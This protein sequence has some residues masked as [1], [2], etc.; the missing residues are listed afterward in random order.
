MSPEELS[1]KLRTVELFKEFPDSELRQLASG[2]RERSIEKGEVVVR[3]GEQ[4]EE[5][6]LVLE[7][8]FEVFLRQESLGFEKE[9]N[10]LGPGS[11][12]GEVS[13]L[14][15]GPRLASVRALSDARALVLSRQQLMSMLEHSPSLGLGLC[16]GMAG[17]L[18]RA[19]TG[20]ASFAHV[21]LDDYPQLR[22][23]HELIPPRISNFCQAL[24]LARGGDRVTVAMVNPRDERARGFLRDVLRRYRVEF[25][26]MSER[27]FDRHRELLLGPSL[28]PLSSADGDQLFYVNAEGGDE[29]LGEHETATVLQDV[30]GQAIRV[31]ASDI[32]FEPTI[33]A[34]RV[35]LRIDGN[36]LPHSTQMP[37]RLFEQ[38]ISRL[39]VMSGMDI[40][41]RRTPQ[42]GRFPLKI[43]SRQVEMRSSAMPCQ[44]GEKF[45]LRLLDPIQRKLE[46]DSLIY[47][48]PVSL[49]VRDLFL[50]PSGLMLVCGPTGAGKTTTLYA[51]LNAIWEDSQS[52]N[53]MTVEDPVEYQ[54]EFATQVSVNRAVGL[55]FAQILRSVLRQDPDVMLVGEIRDVE[56]AAIALEAATTGHLVLSSLHTDF[57]LEAVVRLRNLQAKSYL[58]GSALRGV[59]SQR[60]APR[61]CKS[62]A[63][64]IDAGDEEI[65]RLRDQGILNQDWNGKLQR[66]RGCDLCR[67]H[68]ELGRIGIYEILLVSKELRSLIETEAP[69][70]TLHAALKPDEFISMSRYS[71]FLL[72]EGVVAPERIH[73]IFPAR[74]I[75]TESL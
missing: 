67:K 23:V 16:R 38:V 4:G 49:L 44:G 10:L 24:A 22:E 15:G 58:L 60:L 25:C 1:A 12:F 41:H 32:H 62:C 57:A 51:G 52:I 43:G 66:G 26:A 70:S 3:E 39:K 65:Q 73:E 35:R 18:A 59:I 36:M 74:R 50:S 40:T 11:Y 7:G 42:D 61:V 46:L 54:L 17:Y 56:S 68:G 28:V 2:F 45:V 6:F 34:G 64:P 75:V 8:D 69:W 19:H 5:F 27:D 48:R 14:A 13:L 37:H 21:D 33:G 31:G 55:D 9:L 47:S 53:I 30:L 29:A 20:Q 63:E 71:R 72:E